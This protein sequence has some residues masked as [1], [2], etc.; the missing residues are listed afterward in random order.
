MRNRRVLAL[1]TVWSTVAVLALT[2][3]GPAAAQGG[4]RLV[5]GQVLGPDGKAVEG[6]M[7][8]LINRKTKKQTSV[9]T[10]EEGRYRFGGLDPKVSYRVHAMKDGLKSRQRSISSFSKKNRFVIHLRLKAKEDEEG[11]DKK[12]SGGASG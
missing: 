10:G 11:K 7:V 12:D 2:G 9:V 1:L 4:S 8:V 6:A 3:A 5:E